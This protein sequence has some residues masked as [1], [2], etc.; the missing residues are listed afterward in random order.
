M[1]IM[2]FLDELSDG[3]YYLDGYSKLN[4]SKWCLAPINNKGQA[5]TNRNLIRI[6]SKRFR[7]KKDEYH[8]PFWSVQ[9]FMPKTFSF[10][11]IFETE[12]IKYHDMAVEE[13]IQKLAE[14][15]L[16]TEKTKKPISSPI[17]S[18]LDYS[19]KGK[20]PWMH[21]IILIINGSQEGKNTLQHLDYDH[22]FENFEN[23]SDVYHEKFSQL[24]V[25]NGHPVRSTIRGQ[26]EHET[27]PYIKAE[28]AL[29][30]MRVID[31]SEPLTEEDEYND[32]F[33]NLN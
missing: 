18:K 6:V 9:L 28:N 19:F 2:R 3:L 10:L 17:I 8:Y 12:I 5:V 33:F 27:Y 21:S 32:A 29:R 24:L 16:I 4:N 11:S 1:M 7:A 25:E 14:C 30:D 26:F 23:I 15:F 22:F 20:Y 13:A 31:P